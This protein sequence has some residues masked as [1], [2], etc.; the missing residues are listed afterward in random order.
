MSLQTK[1]DQ[2]IKD[3]ALQ[4]DCDDAEIARIKAEL[5]ALD[6]PKLRHGDYNAENNIYLKQFSCKTDE[7]DMLSSCVK[8]WPDLSFNEA[9]GGFKPKDV[10]GNIFDD[11]ERNREDFE[12]VELGHT[13]IHISKN[14]N[15][16][17]E[18]DDGDM[19]V[20][21]RE[22]I[23]EFAKII[24]HAAAHVARKS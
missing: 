24:S 18:D 13:E 6:G 1:L 5:A 14:G 12:D 23:A 11:L 4:A 9:G 19:V 22:H 2:A 16:L 21:Q 3:K 17:L 10:L 20:I 8:C 7:T 15:L